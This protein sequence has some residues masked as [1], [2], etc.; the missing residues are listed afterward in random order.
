MDDHPALTAL[1]AR[2]RELPLPPVQGGRVELLVQRLPEERRLTPARARLDPELGMEGDRW[3]LGPRKLD[4]QVTLMRADVA[5]MLL[6]GGGVEVFGDNLFADLDTSAANLPAGTRLRVGAALCEV[7]PK[8]HRGCSK[9]ARRA[10]PSG[11]VFLDLPAHL[12]MQLRGVHLR[13][14]EGG[15]VAVGDRV[16]KLA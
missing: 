14:L 8:P 16:E 3:A 6:A 15:E 1:L 5:R 10:L 13:V 2:F 9:F 7:T 12:P 4:A 11:R